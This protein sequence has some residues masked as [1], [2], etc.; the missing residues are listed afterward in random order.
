MLT[1]QGRS[2]KM[3]NYDL[4]IEVTGGMELSTTPPRWIR[5]SFEVEQRTFDRGNYRDQPARHDS[6]SCGVA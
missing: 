2:R 3:C 5:M 6:L 4:C 1:M